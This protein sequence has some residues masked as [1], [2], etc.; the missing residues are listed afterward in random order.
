MFFYSRCMLQCS[1]G[2]RNLKKKM[3][4]QLSGD[5]NLVFIRQK[6]SEIGGNRA[7]LFGARSQ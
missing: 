5:G 4:S 2:L 7:Q 1:N 6:R 3:A